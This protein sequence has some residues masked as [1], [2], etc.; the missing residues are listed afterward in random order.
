MAMNICDLQT[1]RLSNGKPEDCNDC[2][3]KITALD[4]LKRFLYIYY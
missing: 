1:V 3:E 2:F 4:F